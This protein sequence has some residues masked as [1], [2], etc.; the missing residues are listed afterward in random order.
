MAK[1]RGAGMGPGETTMT[2]FPITSIFTALAAV[3]LVLLSLP[4]AMRRRRTG[5]SLG[6]G[7][8][9][10]MSRLIRT[11]GNFIEYVPLILIAMA[12]AEANGTQPEILWALGG[13]AA[14]GRLLHAMAI[15]GGTL[16]PRVA[17]M[18]LTWL[19]LL[20]AAGVLAC[21]VWGVL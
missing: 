16:P 13:A 3:A 21:G 20:A 4:V 9:E 8:D 5:L 6:D 17:G 12:L 18:L 2:A 15:L 7:G 1:S 11:Q 19:T 10:S 14:A